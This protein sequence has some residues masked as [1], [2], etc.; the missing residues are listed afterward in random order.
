MGG[1][2]LRDREESQAWLWAHTASR[3]N[4]KT[5][6]QP[7]TPALLAASLRVS[8]CLTSAAIPPRCGAKQPC[9]LD[10]ARCQPFAELRRHCAN[11]LGNRTCAT[12]SRIQTEPRLY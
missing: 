3:P 8:A 1:D 7:K 12:H 9:V 4:A 2:A 5:W 11:I 10:C 6:D